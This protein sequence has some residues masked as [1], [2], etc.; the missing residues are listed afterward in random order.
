MNAT[1]LPTTGLLR[2]V[3]PMR[4]R[5]RL[6][7]PALD[8]LLADAAARWRAFEA[9]RPGYHTY[10]HA[11][12]RAAVPTLRQLQPLAGTFLECGSGLGVIA[13]IADLL[14]YDAYGIEL[15]P[16]LHGEGQAL[17]QRHG[18]QVTFAQG[19]FMPAAARD[20]QEHDSGEFL[21]V[22]DGEPAYAE[23]GMELRDF[24]VVYAFPWPGEEQR[25]LDLV[26]RHGRK[27]TFLV[28]YGAADGYQ[29]FQ[30]GRP[31]EFE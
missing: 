2:I 13:A 27:D 26:R 6:T 30:K 8:A 23:L 16:W 25:F 31:I 17:A 28:L 9:V 1:D 4:R 10:V 24:D 12:W 29:V 22:R 21:T 11:D 20:Q 7:A 3:S 5:D 19:S 14:G 18:A 15:D